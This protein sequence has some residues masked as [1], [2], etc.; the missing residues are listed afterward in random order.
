[1]AKHEALPLASTA[2]L[3]RSRTRLSLHI[4]CF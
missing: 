1:V 4:C 2:M 3:I